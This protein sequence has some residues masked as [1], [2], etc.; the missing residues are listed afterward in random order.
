MRGFTLIEML[1]T[2]AVFSVASVALAFVIQYFY[3]TNA[4]VFEQTAAVESARNG[5]IH[6]M[7]DLR[8]ASYGSDGSYPIVSAATSSVTFYVD[9][10]GDGVIDRVRYYLGGTTLYRGV[11]APAGNPPSYTGQSEATDTIATY[12]HMSPSTPIFR[13]YDANGTELVP[14]VDVADIAS[15]NTT[16]TVN[17]NPA[18]APDDF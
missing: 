4:Y 7:R 5:I 8:E 2:I 16:V 17:L 13:Y 12:V 10:K 14:P 6:A 3:R 15:V 9:E 11:T 1:V 18:R